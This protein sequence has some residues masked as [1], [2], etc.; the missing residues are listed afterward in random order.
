MEPYCRDVTPYSPLWDHAQADRIYLRLPLNIP[1]RVRELA[2]TLPAVP[3]TAMTRPG[4]LAEAL[5]RGEWRY[6]GHQ[7]PAV[8]S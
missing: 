4:P 5:R 6:P 2:Q 1:N 3:T 8:G 7:M